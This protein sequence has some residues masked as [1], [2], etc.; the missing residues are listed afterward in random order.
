MRV[1]SLDHATER[2]KFPCALVFSRRGSLRS[3]AS[4]TRKARSYPTDAMRV[5]SLDHA[6]EVISSVCAF[7]FSRRGKEG[8]YGAFHTRKE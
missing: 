2:M 5:P 8:R 1:P 6:T 7:V 3:V 4:H